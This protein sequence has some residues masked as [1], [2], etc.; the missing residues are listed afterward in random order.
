MNIQFELQHNEI[1]IANE[2]I[3]VEFHNADCQRF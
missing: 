3:K 2:D 1:W